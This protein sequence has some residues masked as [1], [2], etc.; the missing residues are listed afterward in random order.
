M[1]VLLFSLLVAA[2]FHTSHGASA[3]DELPSRFELR[4]GGDDTVVLR[5]VLINGHL[6]RREEWKL[7]RE[8]DGQVEFRV[9]E[10]GGVA[11]TERV[12]VGSEIV[13]RCLS[14][15]AWTKH[16]LLQAGSVLAESCQVQVLARKARS[17]RSR[18]GP[19]TPRPG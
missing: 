12:A 16:C 18:L 9:V 17:P 8:I 5:C 13:W 14:P 1:P 10:D 15:E 4:V 2:T 6:L 11:R 3:Q 7:V 19:V